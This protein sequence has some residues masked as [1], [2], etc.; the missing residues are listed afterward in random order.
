MSSSNN[1]LALITECLKREFSTRLLGIM[2]FGSR[3]HLDESVGA[4]KADA[5]IAAI[6][7]AQLTIENTAK[8]V[9]ALFIPSWI[10]NH[11]PAP[12]L[13]EIAKRVQEEE[14]RDLIEE[15]AEIT[16]IAAPYHTGSSYGNAERRLTPRQVYTRREAQILIKRANRAIDIALH[17]TSRILSRKKHE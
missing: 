13:R 4:L 6:H 8:A 15:P 2:L 16:E 5:Y 9:I 11:N 12:E 7:E 17:V 3:E 1:P 10:H 14:I